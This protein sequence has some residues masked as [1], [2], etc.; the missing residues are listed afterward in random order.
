[1][2]VVSVDGVVTINSESYNF[3]IK[4]SFTDIPRNLNTT[5]G[6]S[7]VGDGVP[8]KLNFDGSP[9]VIRR[10]ERLEPIR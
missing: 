3:D 9:T 10:S 7:I 1:M 4:S 2:Y 5:V 6:K 8:F